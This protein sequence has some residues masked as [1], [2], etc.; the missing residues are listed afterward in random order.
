VFG[1]QPGEGRYLAGALVMVY[2]YDLSE[3]LRRRKVTYARYRAEQIALL[4][5]RG[6]LIYVI[7]D[8]RLCVGDLLIEIIQMIG[9]RLLDCL[10]LDTGSQAIGL[11]VAHI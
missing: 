11:L 4:L 2:V 5:K 8:Q 6:V 10:G 3:Q 1:Y 7:T 9:D